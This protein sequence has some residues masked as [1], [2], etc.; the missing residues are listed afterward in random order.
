MAS[1]QSVDMQTLA[2][3]V[4]LTRQRLRR[5]NLFDLA[6]WANTRLP[7]RLRETL[8]WHLLYGSGTAPQMHGFLNSTQM[9]AK[10]VGTD[11]WST[12]IE[13]G[14]N[15]ADLVLWAA[16]QIPGDRQIYAVMHK[17][18]WFKLT[19]AK[20]QN[21]NYVHGE[22]EG[23]RIID[24]PTLKAIGGIRVVTSSK[25]VQTYGLVIDPMGA[26][27]LGP[28]DDAEM[29]VGYV[30]DQLIQNQEVQS[31][32]QMNRY[33]DIL[34]INKESLDEIYAAN[35][36]LSIINLVLVKDK[37]NSKM[38]TQKLL[39]WY[40]NIKKIKSVAKKAKYRVEKIREL[41]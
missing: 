26:S 31:F 4:I 27:S 29:V 33:Q 30:N 20:D 1:L 9:T 32:L 37:L 11:T 17:L 40:K 2:T 23:P 21:G 15:R 25:I 6:A 13:D 14:G 19:N 39:T 22:G 28:G 16:A 18:D 24:T 3:Y 5:T 8:E 34:Y 10:S 7:I 41:L 36:Y 35:F 38:V 12:D